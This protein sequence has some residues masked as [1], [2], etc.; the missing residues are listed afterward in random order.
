MGIKVSIMTDEAIE[1]CRSDTES[2]VRKMYGSPNDNGWFPSFIGAVPF[3]ERKFEID[4]PILEV[5]QGE[6]TTEIRIKNAIAIHS[7]LKDLPSFILGDV[8]FWAWASFSFGYSYA[9]S[10]TV[11]DV[12]SVKANWVPR[13]ENA[14]RPT[15]LQ[16]LGREYF[17][18]DL[19]E[20][21]GNTPFE[22]L[23]YLLD[24]NALYFG[25]V[26]RNFSDIPAVTNAII[27]GFAE[28]SKMNPS[29][30]IGVKEFQ[31]VLKEISNLGSVRLID[32]IPEDELFSFVKDRL[33]IMENK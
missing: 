6:I 4:P 19:T 1:K 26:Y 3:E 11:L 24:N 14:R 18:A 21:I 10:R 33:A 15:M 13:G 32:V 23:G 8:R 20:N 9:I 22:Y 25:L 7:S 29:S 2:L 17:M 28:T 5:P 27:K 16:V 31:A 30:S 12:A